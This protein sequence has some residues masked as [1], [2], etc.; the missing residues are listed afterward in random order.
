MPSLTQFG[1]FRHL[2]FF[3]FFSNRNFS[4][5]S[6]HWICEKKCGRPIEISI[7]YQCDNAMNVGC[8]KCFR[9]SVLYWK[10]FSCYIF[11]YQFQTLCNCMCM[12]NSYFQNLWPPTDSIYILHT[13]ARTSFL[14]YLR[15]TVGSLFTQQW[16]QFPITHQSLRAMKIVLRKVKVHA[17]CIPREVTFV[18]CSMHFSGNI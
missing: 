9:N 6:R 7:E 18:W 8:T 17:H 13:R 5:F 14:D 1:I 4:S 3:R 11:L 12:K 16:K 2:A 15:W 10:S